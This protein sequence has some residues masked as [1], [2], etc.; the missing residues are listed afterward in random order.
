MFDN[1]LE[2]SVNRSPSVIFSD[3][4]SIIVKENEYST[5]LTT[6]KR[7]TVARTYCSRAVS[8]IASVERYSNSQNASILFLPMS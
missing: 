8:F 6:I 1:R 7:R 2:T 5:K 4:Y 3:T